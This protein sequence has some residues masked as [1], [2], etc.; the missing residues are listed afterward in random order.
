MQISILI[1]LSMFAC[2]LT[3]DQP[4]T[5]YSAVCVYSYDVAFLESVLT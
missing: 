5:H 2:L 1:D 4:K 3:I